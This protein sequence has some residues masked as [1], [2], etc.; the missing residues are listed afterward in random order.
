MNVVLS[1][2]LSINN[3][4]PSIGA[5]D[6]YTGDSNGHTLVSEQSADQIQLQQNDCYALPKGQSEMHE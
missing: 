1:I 3:C 4:F 6:D 2:L 5:N